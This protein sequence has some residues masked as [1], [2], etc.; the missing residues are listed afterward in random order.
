MQSTNQSAQ[1]IAACW[2]SLFG[3]RSRLLDRRGHPRRRT[4]DRARSGTMDGSA[5]G[6]RRQRRRSYPSACLERETGLW[7]RGKMSRVL[8]WITAGE[9][10]GRALVAVVEGMVAGVRGHVHRDRRPAG[11]PPARLRPR[12]ADEVRARRGD[13]AVRAC[14]TASRWAGPIAIEIGNTEWP[15]WETVMAA[16]PVD[17][18]EL[19]EIGAQRAADPAAARPRRLRGHAQVRLRR[20]PAGAGAGQ[21]PRDRRPRRGGDHRARVPAAGARRRGAL[22]R[23]RDRPVGALRRSA[24]AGRRPARDRRQPGPRLRQGRRS[25]P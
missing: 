5:A 24:A 6:P 9:S 21:R 25:R 2:L 23:H 14:A 10:H 1:A 17:P 4:Y 19:A 18:A 20:R 12:R 22:P 13:R 15:K 8:R 3:A 11:P 16:D 7:R